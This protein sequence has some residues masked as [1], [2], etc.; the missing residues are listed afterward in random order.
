LGG[1]AT[2][3]DDL[4]LLAVARDQGDETGPSPEDGDT[5]LDDGAHDIGGRDAG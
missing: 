3:A 1:V 2:R 5:M 4:Q